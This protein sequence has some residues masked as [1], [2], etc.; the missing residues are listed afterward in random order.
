MPLPR[1]HSQVLLGVFCLIASGCGGLTLGQV[2]GQVKSN[3]KIVTQGTI[4][5][6]PE[7]GPTAVG[8]IQPD[9]TYTLSTLKPNDGALVGSHRVT[10]HATKVDPGRLETPKSFEEELRQGQVKNSGKV[11]VAGQV[12]WIVPEIHSL[13][14]TTKLTAQVE[15]GV[16][17]IDFDVPPE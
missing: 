8:T 4:M 17:K 2:S 15:R 9:G 14:E 1:S 7:K 13:A 5:F 3:G 10:I 12:H 6:H 11:L 16:N